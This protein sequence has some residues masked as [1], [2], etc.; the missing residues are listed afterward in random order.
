MVVVG[1][2]VSKK[3]TTRNLIKRRIRAAFRETL[4]QAKGHYLAIAQPEITK[5][6]FVELKNEL[7][8]QINE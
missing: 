2:V 3:A 5:L 1:R 7:E 6:S 4:K 8:K